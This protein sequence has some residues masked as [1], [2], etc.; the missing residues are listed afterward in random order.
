MIDTTQSLQ[1]LEGD[2][3]E[4]LKTIPDDSVDL[5]MTS[6]LCRNPHKG[7]YA[8]VVFMRNKSSFSLETKHFFKFHST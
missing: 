3:R 7:D 2:C 1:I 8:E 4:L 5:T 6:P